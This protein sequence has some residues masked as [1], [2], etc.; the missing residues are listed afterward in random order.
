MGGGE[1]SGAQR[2]AASPAVH[3]RGFVSDP[4]LA[5]A[6]RKA[7]FLV[8]PSLVYE[9][10]PMVIAE[11]FSAGLPI[12]ASRLGA[13]AE[14][15]QDGV[16]GL[17]FNVG[18][19]ADLAAKVQWAADQPAAMRQMSINARETY[20]RHYTPQANYER[21]MEIYNEACRVTPTRGARGS[22][23]ES[24]LKDEG[25]LDGLQQSQCAGRGRGRLC[26]LGLDA[27][28]LQAG[29]QVRVLDQLIY[30]N[31]FALQHLL[32][33]ERLKFMR[34]DLRDAATFARAADGVKT[35]CCWRHWWATRSA[36]STRNLRSM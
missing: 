28:L 27:R 35:S 31:G 3:I 9:G 8:L 26:R 25:A 15:V 12:I 5:A 1:L 16:T 19:A 13:M 34:G 32:D 6:M 21:L 22:D 10:F 4:E 30:D 17:H 14:L 18:D 33:S 7:Q 11:A 29:A 36:R 24:S 2:A 20:V 23:L